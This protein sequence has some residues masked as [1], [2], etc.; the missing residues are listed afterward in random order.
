MV[1]KNSRMKWH[2]GCSGFY[3][4]DWKNKFYPTGLP[5][6]EWLSYYSK[7]FDTVEINA[8]FYNFPKPSFLRSLY[9]HSHD[10]FIFSVKVPRIITHYKNSTTQNN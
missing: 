7:T 1:S 3:Y 8:T 4:H 10:S 6:R 2:I 9:S 5:Q